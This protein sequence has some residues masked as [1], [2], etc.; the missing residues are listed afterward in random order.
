MNSPVTNRHVVIAIPVL[1]VG[2]TEIQTLNLVK[3]LKSGGYQ[4]SVCCYFE[5]DDQMIRE[6][7]AV[8][9]HVILMKLNREE[10]LL[11]VAR[12][13]IGLFK[14]LNPDIVHIQYIAPGFIPVLAARM[15][16]INTVFATV[17][18]PG[19]TY[20][21]NAKLLLRIAAR[22]CT[23]FFC[24]SRAVEESWFGDSE[25]FDPQGYKSG[26]KHFT[27]YNAIDINRLSEIVGSVDREEMR[28][29][30]G[31]GKGPVV[32]VVA[33]L[34][35]EKGHASL[36]EAMVVVIKKIPEAILLV[37][38]DGPDREKL[39]QQA[40]ALGI[41]GHVLWLGQKNPAEVF[42]L[43]AIMDVLAVPSFFEGFGLS[44][45]EAMAAQ[46]PVVATRVD[47]L[48][49][50]I[51]D[52][53]SGYL[54]KA[55]DGKELTGAMTDLLLDSAKAKAMGHRGHAYVKA[56]FSLE[57]FKELMILV[58]GCCL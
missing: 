1:R 24:N 32:G 8:G 16:G 35:A 15:V 34:R 58:Y 21:W 25:L 38:G 46:V 12:N 33:R 52:G 4:V 27:I 43:Y 53:V 2:G 22:L 39:E 17:H 51:E 31:M 20:G 18:Q 13:L 19:R 9:A 54:V 56:N 3:V 26:R 57:Q 5:Y 49:E 6:M 55:G 28:H 30:L 50:V 14:K 41:A 44:A 29:S 42:R 40:H 11:R 23:A 10:G 37:V 7:E 45:A 47:G 48:P 36:L